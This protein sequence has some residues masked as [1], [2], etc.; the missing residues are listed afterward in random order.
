MLSECIHPNFAV[1]IFDK[2]LEF[3]QDCPVFFVNESIPNKMSI[4]LIEFRQLNK[5]MEYR[6]ISD[7]KESF[8]IT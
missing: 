2:L 5:Y 4:R 1:K 7:T 6:T 3:W 8:I